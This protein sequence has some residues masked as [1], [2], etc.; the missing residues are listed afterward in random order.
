VKLLAPPLGGLRV[1]FVDEGGIVNVYCVWSGS[2]YRTEFAV[3]IL[4]HP[5]VLSAPVE[6]V[7]A[8]VPRRQG[9]RNGSLATHARPDKVFVKVVNIAYQ[10]ACSLESLPKG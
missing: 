8:I 7:I 3:H 10:R 4:D 6:V 9:W 1:Y 5:D 2:H